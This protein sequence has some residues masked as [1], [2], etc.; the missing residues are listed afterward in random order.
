MQ[1]FLS[2]NPE[3]SFEFKDTIEMLKEIEFQPTQQVQ[4]NTPKMQG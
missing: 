2:Q 1:E 4:I 3:E